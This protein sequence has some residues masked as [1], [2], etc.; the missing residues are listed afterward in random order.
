MPPGMQ[1]AWSLRA[2]NAT[3]RH[4]G[5]TRRQGTSPWGA[6]YSTQLA[7]E[8]L[9]GWLGNHDTSPGAPAESFSSMPMPGVAGVGA[10]ADGATCAL[11]AGLCT[12]AGTILRG[13]GTVAAGIAVTAP[14]DSGTALLTCVPAPRS[15]QRSG[16]SEQ[17]GA[18][19]AIC[20]TSAHASRNAAQMNGRMSFTKW[21]P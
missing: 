20:A 16:S 1:Q 4:P 15:T 3:P 19:C 10:E 17:V 6:V 21:P 9:A 14:A 2:A 5:V 13:A 7:P 8:L 12:G 11:A 18:A